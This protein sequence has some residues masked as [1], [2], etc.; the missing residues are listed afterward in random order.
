MQQVLQNNSP[1]ACLQ[2]E[3]ALLENYN[4]NYYIKDLEILQQINLS[5]NIELPVSETYLAM[6]SLFS[7]FYPLPAVWKHRYKENRPPQVSGI[8]HK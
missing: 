4:A 5:N 8:S 3:D 1:K 6:E 7:I 2:E